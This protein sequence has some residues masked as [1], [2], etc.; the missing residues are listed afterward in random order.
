MIEKRSRMI[1]FAV[2]AAV[3]VAVPISFYELSDS[4]YPTI[5]EVNNNVSKVVW[6]INDSTSSTNPSYFP[7]LR[8]ISTF[9]TSDSLNSTIS[10]SSSVGRGSFCSEGFFQII[11]CNFTIAGNISGYLKPTSITFTEI[12]ESNV[13]YV[14]KFVVCPGD[15]QS[16]NTSVINPWNFWDYNS[17][18]VNKTQCY[19]GEAACSISLLNEPVT[20]HGLFATQNVHNNFSYKFEL[21]NNLHLLLVPRNNGQNA[22]NYFL[23]LTVT[24]NGLA[25]QVLDQINIEVIRVGG[26]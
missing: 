3:I 15:E 21:I 26:P 22:S 6:Y 13:P 8:S 1:T 12:E 17:V 25:K 4:P 9:T 20:Q 19:V 5:V 18:L 24:L 16:N 23:S 2:I 10:L 11:I 14:M 7:P